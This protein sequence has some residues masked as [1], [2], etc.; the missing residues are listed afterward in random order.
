MTAPLADIMRPKTIEDMVG[1]THLLS[2]NKPLYNII[3]S[4][5]ETILLFIF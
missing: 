3:K 1:Q 2:E 5:K 4:K